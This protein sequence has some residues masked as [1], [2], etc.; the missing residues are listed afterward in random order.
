MSIA[1][2]KIGLQFCCIQSGAALQST[3]ARIAHEAAAER[4]LRV[5]VSIHTTVKGD[6]V[7]SDRRLVLVMFCFRKGTTMTRWPS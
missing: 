1:A 4:Y 3:S 5:A 7:K 6:L 2:N